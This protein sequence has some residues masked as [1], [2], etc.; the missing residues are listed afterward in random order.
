MKREFACVMM[1][2]KGNKVELWQPMTWNERTR[3]PEVLARAAHQLHAAERAR[4]LGR[5]PRD[6]VRAR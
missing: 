2:P 3:I 1:D 4:W 6:S 5:Y